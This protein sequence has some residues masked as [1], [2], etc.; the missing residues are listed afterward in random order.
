MKLAIG[1][2]LEECT[3]R[4]FLGMTGS[5]FAAYRDLAVLSVCVAGT[6]APYRC[7]RF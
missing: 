1:H 7:R 5:V 2:G 6:A 3:V 4:E